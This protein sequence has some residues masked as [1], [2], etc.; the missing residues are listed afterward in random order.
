MTNDD[1]GVHLFRVYEPAQSMPASAQLDGSS[2][3]CSL[4]EELAEGRYTVRASEHSATHCELAVAPGAVS[5]FR[6][7][8]DRQQVEFL[9]RMLV[10]ETQKAVA[11]EVNRSIATV[12]GASRQSLRLLGLDCGLLYVPYLVVR[13]AHVASG[14]KL[15]SCHVARRGTAGTC[16]LSIERPDR[17]LDGVLSE[18]ERDV[19]GLMLEG[20]PNEA[21]ARRRDVAVRTIANQISSVFRKLHVSGRNELLCALVRL[22]HA[23]SFPERLAPKTIE[24]SNGRPLCG[25]PDQ[26]LMRSADAPVRP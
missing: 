18:I 19:A 17:H 15:P 6:S 26:R 7:R 4:W 11:Y 22:E 8:R 16:Y 2:L 1:A 25:R 12:A 5:T 20:Y 9:R 3:G 10:G 21:I 24:P 23:R 14:L 13:A